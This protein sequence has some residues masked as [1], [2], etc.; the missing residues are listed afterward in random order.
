MCKIKKYFFTFSRLNDNSL[1]EISVLVRRQAQEEGR[2]CKETSARIETIKRDAHARKSA[3]AQKP[4][5][6]VKIIDVQYIDGY[7]ENKQIQ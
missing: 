7:V 6:D 3:R 2:A 4:Q 1:L 5:E